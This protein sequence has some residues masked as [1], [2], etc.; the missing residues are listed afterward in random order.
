MASWYFIGGRNTV[1]V[2]DNTD[3]DFAGSEPF[4]VDGCKGKFESVQDF[5]PSIELRKKL[6][7]IIE[8]NGLITIAGDLHLWDEEWTYPTVLKGDLNSG[9]ILDYFGDRTHKTDLIWIKFVK[10]SN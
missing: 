8:P 4:I 1:A 7:V 3:P 2:D 9:E 5:N 10:V 6:K